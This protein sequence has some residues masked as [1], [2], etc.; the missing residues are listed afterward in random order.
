M[1][2]PRDRSRSSVSPGEGQYSHRRTGRWLR[3]N[4]RGAAAASLPCFPRPPC[5]RH[6]VSI[7]GFS[8]QPSKV[9][10]IIPFHRWKD[11]DSARRWQSQ[12]SNPGFS[13]SE[14]YI[15]PIL[16]NA[17]SLEPVHLSSAGR[18]RDFMVLSAVG[19]KIETW[20]IVLVLTKG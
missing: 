6:C 1:S 17:A 9:H 2:E 3:C 16:A 10:V 20:M 14:A 7:I 5:F 12:A 8:Q 11:C 15:F 18:G 19:N 4:T 13:D